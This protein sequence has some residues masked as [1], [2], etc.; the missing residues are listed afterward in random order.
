[1]DLAIRVEGEELVLRKVSRQ[2][3]R[4]WQGRLKGSPLL[5]DLAAERRNELKRD[6][7]GS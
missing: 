7:K 6:A 3:W 2:S 5:K 1:M 4:S